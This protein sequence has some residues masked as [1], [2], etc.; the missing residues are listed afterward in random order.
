MID[1]VLVE[2]AARVASV[3]IIHVR[4]T[5]TPQN[6]AETHVSKRRRDRARKTEERGER[7]G[8][9]ASAMGE[10]PP[11]PLMAWALPV[12]LSSTTIMHFVRFSFV[13][14]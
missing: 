8:E 3:L 10:K 11:H 1:Y 13:F 12:D 5:I 6:V 14:P 4:P 9:T 7:G 2:G